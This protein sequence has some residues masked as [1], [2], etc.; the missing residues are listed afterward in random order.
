MAAALAI[1][2]A[3]S[4]GFGGDPTAGLAADGAQELVIIQEGAGKV[5]T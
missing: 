4:A 2:G 1:P 5:T 3:V